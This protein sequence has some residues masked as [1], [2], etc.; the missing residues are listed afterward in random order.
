MVSRFKNSVGHVLVNHGLGQVWEVTVRVGDGVGQE[1][2]GGEKWDNSSRI[3]IESD[4]IEKGK[5]SDLL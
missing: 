1:G 4:L 2:Q 5:K 3:T